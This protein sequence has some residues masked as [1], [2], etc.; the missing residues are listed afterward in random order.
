MWHSSQFS[1]VSRGTLVAAGLAIM[2]LGCGGTSG[3][4]LQP[5]TGTLTIDGKPVSNV[6][7]S[8]MPTDPTGPVA[9]GTCDASG[10]YELY[11]GQANRKGAVA[12]SYKIVLNQLSSSNPEDD[13]ARYTSGSGGPPKQTTLPFPSEFQQSSTSPK[14]VDVRVGSNT[15]DITIP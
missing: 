9:S 6:Q 7:V 5:V 11:S 13:T 14:Q 1:R 3:P 10:R 4:P 12:G 15:I 8:F 2:A